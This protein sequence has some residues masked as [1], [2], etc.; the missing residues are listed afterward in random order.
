MFLCNHECYNK[1]LPMSENK[2]SN[3]FL[4]HPIVVFFIIAR[5]LAALYILV[6]PFWGFVAYLFFDFVDGYL[7]SKP[8]LTTVQYMKFDRPL[9]WLG[10]LTMLVVVSNTRFFPFF[11]ILLGFRLVGQIYYMKTSNVKYYILFPNFYEVFY[12]WFIVLYLLDG[13]YFI[14]GAREVLFLILLFIFQFIRELLIHK[15]QH[16]YLKKHGQY[17][18]ALKLGFPER[19]K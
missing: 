16:D 19:R 10:Y 18:I 9:D 3:K 1:L 5:I 2:S 17:K 6:E 4:T 11:L 14:V 15:Y 12:V 8:G 7:F 13:R